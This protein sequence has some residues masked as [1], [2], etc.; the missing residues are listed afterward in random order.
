MAGD[1]ETYDDKLEYALDTKNHAYIK[2]CIKNDFLSDK[3][4]LMILQEYSEELKN[5]KELVQLLINSEYFDIDFPISSYF[6]IIYIILNN[7]EIYSKYLLNNDNYMKLLEKLID[8]NVDD[9]YILLGL[10]P[11]IDTELN[12]KIVNLVKEKKCI[13]P[14]KEDDA[15]YE[16][17]LVNAFNCGNIVAF[18]KYM[19]LIDVNNIDKE[20]CQEIINEINN[21]EH[22]MQKYT[23]Y[24]PD[25]TCD[26][27][28]VINLYNTQNKI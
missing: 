8:N 22:F 13:I 25:Y 28:G 7:S 2:Y 21:N 20:E 19:R 3:R 18:K 5:N 9:V 23:D 6:D 4:V 17:Y 16:L 15:N 14:I 27:N 10:H 12:E 26:L 11:F 1:V 24:C